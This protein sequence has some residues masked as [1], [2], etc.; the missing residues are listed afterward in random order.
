MKTRNLIGTITI[1]LIP[2]MF[3]VSCGLGIQSVREPSSFTETSE[4]VPTP[5]ATLTPKPTVTPTATPRPTSTPTPT[6]DPLADYYSQEYSLT[7]GVVARDGSGEKIPLDI[8]QV[9]IVY[10]ADPGI[11]RESSRFFTMDQNELFFEVTENRL[12]A[13]CFAGVPEHLLFADQWRD[14]AEAR[15]D[16]EIELD[17]QV[18]IDPAEE[19]FVIRLDWDE[20][21]HE[22]QLILEQLVYEQWDYLGHEMSLYFQSGRDAESVRVFFSP[23]SDDHLFVSPET[24]LLMEKP[25]GDPIILFCQEISSYYEVSDGREATCVLSY[26][27]ENI[28]AKDILIEQVFEYVDGTLYVTKYPYFFETHRTV[29]T[30]VELNDDLSYTVSS[31]VEYYLR[32]KDASFE[33][34]IN[35]QLK[36]STNYVPEVLTA[37]TCFYP[38]YLELNESKKGFLYIHLEDGR[39]GRIVAEIKKDG[40]YIDGVPIDEAYYPYY[41]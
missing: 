8:G 20:D 4:T 36:G 2:I 19:R 15:T 12:G 16:I 34:D 24:L 5:T 38:E 39:K 9:V 14:E 40:G 35:I 17:V 25:N 32:E 10:N 7:R 11:I 26:D 33:C 30:A 27:P 3:L 6:P 37:G 41:A 31:G 22:D 18:K 21:G 1:I 29:K 13:I 23:S 28:F